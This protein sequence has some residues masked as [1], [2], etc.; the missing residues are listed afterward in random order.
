MVNP[1]GD[2]LC[3]A[4]NRPCCSRTGC[5]HDSGRGRCLCAIEQQEGGGAGAPAGAA[6]PKGPGPMLDIP[7]PDCGMGDK[8]TLTPKSRRIFSRALL[9]VRKPGR[10]YFLTLTSSPDEPLKMIHWDMVRKKLKK[11]L[12]RTSHFHVITGEGHGVIHIILRLGPG[13]KRLEIK[14]FRTWWA[15]YHKAVQIRIEKVGNVKELARYI[16]DQRHKKNIAG[17][18]AWQDDII[19]WGWSKGWLP[20]GFTKHFGRYWHKSREASMG[21]REA[22]LHGWLLRCFEDPQ[23][24]RRPPTVKCGNPFQ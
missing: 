20:A 16:S 7:T 23:E 18:F 9:G 13:E 2:C 3:A 12:P 21:Q 4:N 15:Q 8:R 6:G 11:E 5:D 19:S 14:P 1:K 22:F 24:I 17:E 10:Y